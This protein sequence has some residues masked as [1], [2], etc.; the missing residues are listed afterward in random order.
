MKILVSG[1]T[2]FIGSALVPALRQD[3]NE[4]HQMI[5]LDRVAHSG[6]VVWKPMQGFIQHRRLDRL[7][8]VIHLAGENIFGR[9]TQHKQQEIRDSRVASTQFL[10]HCLAELN[11][12]PKVFLCAS[13]IGYYGSRGEELLTEQSPPGE[14][15]LAE[16]CRQWETA[17][18]AA[19]QAGIRTVNLRFGAVLGKDGGAMGQMLPIFRKGLGGPIG[20]GRQWMS[21]IS[22]QDL[23]GA[24]RFC[25]ENESITGPVNITAPEPV[26]NKEFTKTLGH[27]LHRPAVMHVPKLALRLKFGQLA[28]D[29]LLASARVIPEKL[30]ATGFQFSCPTLEVA[31]TDL[32][33]K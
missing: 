28:D 19:R 10:A 26:Q 32:L 2:G 22:I 6:D 33:R 9:W 30:T 18:E 16:V 31:L 3:G 29:V 27:V 4:V 8:A 11:C 21:W 23:I 14:G 24:V 12:P 13:A 20:D 25:M 5:R 17:C 1:A 7:D 15:F